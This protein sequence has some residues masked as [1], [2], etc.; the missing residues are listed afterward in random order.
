VPILLD[1]GTKEHPYG[2]RALLRSAR[3]A[4]GESLGEGTMSEVWDL[5]IE[6]AVAGTV[7]APTLAVAGEWSLCLLG[8]RQDITFKV[9]DQDVITDDTGAIVLNLMQQDMLA[10]RCVGRFGFNVAVPA[11]LT[12]GATGTPY[13]FGVLNATA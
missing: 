2:L 11:T 12:E 7:P 9:F 6:Y 5:P 10:L 1:P 3:S 8:V 4:T 13:P